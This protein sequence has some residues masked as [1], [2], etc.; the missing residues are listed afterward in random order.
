MGLRSIPAGFRKL[1]FFS[2]ETAMNAMPMLP[3]TARD[4]DIHHLSLV[5]K[6][7]TRT[8]ADKHGISQTRVRQIVKRVAQWL[9]ESLPAESEAADAATLRLAQHIAAD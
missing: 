1:P 7:S 4:F 2:R 9:S 6:V 5:E 3:P 8:I